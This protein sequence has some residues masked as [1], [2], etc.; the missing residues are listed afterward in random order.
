MP[1][2]LFR[3][4]LV[5]LLCSG[6]SSL[7]GQNRT[8]LSTDSFRVKTFSLAPP[9][10]FD[11]KRFWISAG[12]GTAVYTGVSVALWNAWYKDYPTSGFQTFNDMPEWLGMDKGGH[13]FATW[14]EANFVFHGALWTGMNRRKAMW[15]GVGVGM[16]LQATVEVMDG[17][18]EEWGFSWGDIAFNSVGAGAFIAQELAWEE[19]RIKFKVSAT[20]PDY[21]STPIFSTDGGQ[22]T[23][24]EKRADEL[25]GSTP[26]EVILKDY[27]ATTYWASVNVSAFLDRKNRF[28]K[29]L[30][31]AAGYGA[32]NLYGGFEN[33]WSNDDGAI[34]LLDDA[35]YPRFRQFFFSPDI[36]LT[37]IPTRKRWLKFALGIL[38]VFKVPAPALEFNTMGETRL[39]F[40][41]W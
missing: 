21:P 34:F 32:G 16:G 23:T 12:T 24:L 27:N 8:A 15:T 28:P 3:F 6:T 2:F 9:A 18:S 39:H 40:I 36:D 20:R 38:N 41:Y 11:K 13:L 26:Y 4:L 31:L 30:N 17:F 29:W 37:K 22:Q 5:F 7:V 25:Y 14:M 1:D 35:T 19:Q 33:E 10:S